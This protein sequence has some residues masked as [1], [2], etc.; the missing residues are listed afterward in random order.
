VFAEV[1]HQK[2]TYRA[3]EELRSVGIWLQN[4]NGESKAYIRNKFSTT[5]FT[6]K[7]LKLSLITYPS[8]SHGKNSLSLM[9]QFKVLIL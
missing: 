8:V 3:D 5:D 4:V 1:G 6:A 9:L 2:K 7:I